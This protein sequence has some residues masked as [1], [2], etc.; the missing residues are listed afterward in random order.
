[1]I[2]IGKENKNQILTF[3]PLIKDNY[4]FWHIVSINF[5]AKDKSEATEIIKNFVEAN[6]NVE[7]FC[8]LE[9]DKKAVSIM[10]L[11]TV[12]NYGEIKSNIESK[13]EGKKCKVLAKKMSANG[14]KQI[15]INLT[16]GSDSKAGDVL[17]KER[18]NRAKNVVLI[19]DDDLF[20]RKSLKS[21]LSGIAEIHESEKG[22]DVVGAYL[23]CNP[24]VVILDIHMPERSGLELVNDLNTQDTNA[25]VVVS[26]S[27]SIKENILKAIDGGA[28]GFLAKPAKKERLFEY[29]EQCITF[30]RN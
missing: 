15:Q 4:E 6:Q 14:L 8:Y 22:S 30:R 12:D 16:K 13:L 25:F 20:V 26:S 2:F 7:G 9:N 23:T 5:D 21:L 3:I 24:D 27:D 1:M 10:N 19:A 18:E 17:F 29:L 28:V 11:G